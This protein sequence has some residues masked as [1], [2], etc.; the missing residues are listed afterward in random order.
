MK[1]AGTNPY[2]CFEETPCKAEGGNPKL[3]H[4]EKHG[5]VFGW[6][7]ITFSMWNTTVRSGPFC[8]HCVK[9]WYEDTFEVI[10]PKP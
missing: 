8:V 4:C 6:E 9:N 5:A 2:V 7:P 10:G 3:L 1:Y